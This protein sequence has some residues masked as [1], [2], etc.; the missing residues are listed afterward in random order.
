MAPQ[1]KFH[2]TFSFVMGAMML[3]FMTFVVTAVNLG[4]GPGFLA[5]WGKSFAVAYV[6]GVPT[7]FVLAPLARRITGR[8]LG[9]DP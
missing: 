8:L 7:I 4:F 9:M 3:S 5:A 1:K 6:V 2:L